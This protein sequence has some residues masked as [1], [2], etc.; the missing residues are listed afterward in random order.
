MLWFNNL[1]CGKYGD[2]LRNMQGL[3]DV[4]RNVQGI[5]DGLQNLQGII[6]AGKTVC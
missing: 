4:P 3:G 1:I 5:G 2:G 6:E